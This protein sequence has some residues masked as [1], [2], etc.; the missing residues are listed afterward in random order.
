M[1]D[2][3]FQACFE[4]FRVN[5]A[6]PITSFAAYEL[7]VKAKRSNGTPLAPDFWLITADQ[8]KKAMQ[9][10]RRK[11]ERVCVAP[12]DGG[13]VKPYAPGCHVSLDGAPMTPHGA[14]HGSGTLYSPSTG[15]DT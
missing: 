13:I 10:F 15:V 7:L 14:T 11:K 8:T 6:H 9:A 1:R 12:G 5:Q 2:F 4:S 3:L